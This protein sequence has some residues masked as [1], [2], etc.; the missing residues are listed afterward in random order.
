M[1][2]KH[3]VYSLNQV[4]PLLKQG[5]PELV[6][7]TM[8]GWFLNISKDGDCTASLG[9]LLQHLTT[10][11]IKKGVFSQTASITKWLEISS[12]QQGSQSQRKMWITPEVFNRAA[13]LP[14]YW[15]EQLA[16]SFSLSFSAIAS[17]SPGVSPL[18]SLLSASAVCLFVYL[19]FKVIP[20]RFL[21]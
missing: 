16:L 17:P 8:S 2:Y 7:R 9:R 20:I 3:R 4:Q 14:V 6:S 19:F 18:C 12:Q 10:L 5:H 1:V 15:L 11:T 13:F 21:G